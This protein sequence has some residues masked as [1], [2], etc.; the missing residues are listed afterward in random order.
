MVRR[1][2]DARRVSASRCWPTCRDRRSGSA[3]SRSGA[4]D[5]AARASAS[6]SPPATSRAT[7]ADL[8]HDATRAC[9]TTSTTATRCS[10][11]TGTSRLAV[12]S[13]PPTTDV[14]CEVLI[15]GRDQQQQG[16][17]PARRGGQ[18]AGAVGARTMDDL[19]WALAGRGGHRR[20]VLR[21]AARGHRRRAR[22][23]GRGGRATARSWPR[24]RSRRRSI[25][26]RRSSRPSTGSWSPAA[27]WVWNCRWSRSR[28]CR[29]GPSNC[30]VRPPNR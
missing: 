17:Q 28:W 16:H 22:G 26:W 2:S 14:V 18:R 9:P 29:S 12:R 30:P 19:R 1:A 23:H 8:L 4:V 7:S 11:T 6:P 25:T 15:G 5:L 27:I 20:A 24:S 13:S 21:A 3:R 10:S